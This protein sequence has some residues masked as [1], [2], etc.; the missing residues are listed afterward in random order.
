MQTAKF[1]TEPYCCS[2][3]KHFVNK[4]W[5]YIGHVTFTFH[6]IV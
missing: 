4:F 1:I 5:Q 6:C 3:G 2:L